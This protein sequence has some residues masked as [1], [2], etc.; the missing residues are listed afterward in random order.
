[1]EAEHMIAHWR[2]VLADVTR[3]IKRLGDEGG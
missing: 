1:M 3:R 2:G